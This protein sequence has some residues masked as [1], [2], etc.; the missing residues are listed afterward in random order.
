MNHNLR[1]RSNRPVPIDQPVRRSGRT[2]RRTQ[3]GQLLV[4]GA[5]A[6][7]TL[8]GFAG[9]AVNSAAD[10]GTGVALQVAA[11]AASSSAST[12]WA[13]E[14]AA[15]S[16][17]AAPAHTDG[18]GARAAA[19]AS[20]NGLPL[21]ATD[22]CNNGSGTQYD[23][24]FYDISPGS[25]PS[26]PTGWATSLE[27]R[28]PPL[29]APT[30]GPCFPNTYLCVQVIATNKVHNG[31]MAVLG[32]STTTVAMPSISTAVAPGCTSSTIAK[33][34]GGASTASDSTGG[35]NTAL[36]TALPNP[37]ANHDLLTVTL[38]IA[39]TNTA[40]TV[41]PPAGWLNAT[42]A[43]SVANGPGGELQTQ[44]WYYPNAPAGITSQNW[45]LTGTSSGGTHAV[46]AE[47][48]GVNTTS[49]LEGTAEY[50][51][52]YPAANPSN[53]QTHTDT[54]SAVSNGDLGLA[55]WGLYS[56]P[57]TTIS[58]TRSGTGTWTNME[59]MFFLHD[60]IHETT[61]YN[62][63]GLVPGPVADD[64]TE[65]GTGNGGTN[66]DNGEYNGSEALFAPA[67]VT[68]GSVG[69]VIVQ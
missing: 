7:V 8:T 16:L 63:S 23:L 42:A 49:P 66:S 24:T 48:S 10:R 9:L 18:T 4:V 59:T 31:I 13:G 47:W 65:S 44:I 55:V 35:N 61:D 67:C 30:S 54:A 68:A 50:G 17:T 28:I 11:D 46:M 27:V 19:I 40:Q 69:N 43:N 1:S 38:K 53:V 51:V 34:Q 60:A 20:I 5:L 64:E 3:G 2:R 36:T 62:L 39:G 26:A 56:A 29:P 58:F 45:T 22:V 21:V 57:D 14:V 6:L 15:Q 37:S 52:F 12:F 41:T 33:V 25:C 32:E